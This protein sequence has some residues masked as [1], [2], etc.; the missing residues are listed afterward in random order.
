MVRLAPPTIPGEGVLGVRHVVPARW[1]PRAAHRRTPRRPRAQGPVPGVRRVPGRRGSGGGDLHQEGRA[2]AAARC[3]GPADHDGAGRADRSGV[4]RGAVLRLRPRLVDVRGPQRDPAP[5]RGGRDL[6]RSPGWPARLL[7]CSQPA[8]HSPDDVRGDWPTCTVGGPSS[9]AGCSS[10][11]WPQ[12]SPGSPPVCSCSSSCRSLPASDR[13]RSTPAQQAS[14]AD[15]VGRE[16]NGGQA[17]AAFQMA[18]DSGANPRSRDRRAP[19]G[20]RQLWPWHS[21]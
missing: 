16:R 17:L 5:V 3:S 4:P 8:T 14:L 19:G 18:Q 12:R 7:R 11:A 2:E 13:V 10:A 15:I 21:A 1:H 9:S 20:L 6:G